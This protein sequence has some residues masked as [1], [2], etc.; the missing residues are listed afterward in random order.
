MS[1]ME[2]AK[3]YTLGTALIR[4]QIAASLDD[5]GEMLIKRMRKAHRQAQNALAD[6]LLRHQSRTEDMVPLLHRLLLAFAAEGT[7]G[8]R[9]HAISEVIGGRAAEIMGHCETYQA[10]AGRNH[11]PFLW[12]FCKA[13]RRILFGVLQEADLIATSHDDSL[14]RALSFVKKHQN[15]KSE[16]LSLQEADDDDLSTSLVEKP[17]NVFGMRWVP[18]Q[19]WKLVTGMEHRGT[20]VK[21]VN[22]RYFELCV[23][24][25][26]TNDLQSGDIAIRGSDKFSDYR[27]HF[28]SPEQ[29]EAEV[30]EY[31][32][33]VGLPTMRSAIIEDLKRKLATTAARVDLAFP[34]NEHL[35]IHNG[36]PILSRLEKRVEPEQLK[37][38]ERLLAERLTPVKYSRSHRRHRELA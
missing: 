29:Y 27:E 3:R 26:L 11:L 17:P 8:E 14:I 33:Q 6:Y 30:G 21:Q 24:T 23:F 12:R 25:Q 5:L 34:K 1:E 7:E 37:L 16:W 22:R 9:L 35:R 10:Y 36:E 32:E 2:P 38:V 4:R 15:S 28:V 13:H 19:W 18:G 20:D 31:C